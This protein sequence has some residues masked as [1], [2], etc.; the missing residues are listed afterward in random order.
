MCD[1]ALAGRTA[2]GPGGPLSSVHGSRADEPCVSA[3]ARQAGTHPRDDRGALR[4]YFGL[5][6]D[7]LTPER[8][9]HGRQ[10][11]ERLKTI[12]DSVVHLFLRNDRWILQASIDTD[13]PEVCSRANDRF[14]RC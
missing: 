13:E 2:A 14:G 11:G 6:P 5:G 4:C 7:R 12:A 10:V 3:D 1:S 9:E 8:G